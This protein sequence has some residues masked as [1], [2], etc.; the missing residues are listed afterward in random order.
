MLIEHYYFCFAFM[1]CHAAAHDR[2]GMLYYRVLLAG[3]LELF[4]D[5]LCSCFIEPSARG[6]N[7]HVTMVNIGQKLGCCRT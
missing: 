6:K 4:A 5:F 1:I 7:E 3:G 2:R